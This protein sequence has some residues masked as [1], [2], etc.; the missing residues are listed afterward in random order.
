M[1]DQKTT[2]DSERDRIVRKNREEQLSKLQ[3]KKAEL[4]VMKRRTCS[5]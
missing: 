4:K 2:S 3:E 1:L 5:L